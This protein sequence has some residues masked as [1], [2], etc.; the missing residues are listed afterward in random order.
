MV[1]DGGDIG[2]IVVPWPTQVDAA[3]PMLSPGWT[4]EPGAPL[5]V[6]SDQ[7]W[8]G[9]R[10]LRIEGPCAPLDHLVV[11]QPFAAWTQQAG[12]G[13]VACPLTATV[14]L[15]VLQEEIGTVSATLDGLPST[16]RA[17]DA[18]ALPTFSPLIPGTSLVGA[19][20]TGV[21]EPSGHGDGQ[22]A[23]GCTSQLA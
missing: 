1:V 23:C 9:E 22:H 12:A 6:R 13:D 2:G 19:F 4:L 14:T 10:R 17:I 16:W 21:Q 11:D 7:P 5:R 8:H 18:A 3:P 20:R 15:A